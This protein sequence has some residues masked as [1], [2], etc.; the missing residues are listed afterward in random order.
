MFWH[1]FVLTDRL[2]FNYYG[3]FVMPKRPFKE[4]FADKTSAIYQKMSGHVDE[5]VRYS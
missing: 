4:E 1:L 2:S 5:K 3:K